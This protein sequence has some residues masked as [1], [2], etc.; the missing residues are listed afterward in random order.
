MSPPWQQVSVMAPP[1]TP[2]VQVPFGAQSPKQPRPWQVDFDGQLP[3]PLQLEPLV[4]IPWVHEP[5]VQLSVLQSLPSSQLTH[6]LP[7]TPQWKLE[8]ERHWPNEQQPLVQQA[9]P[10]QWPPLQVLPSL[11]FDHAVSLVVGWQ[12][13]QGFAELTAPEA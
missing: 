9:P 7:E 12:V 4:A 2:L 11:R 3:G 8:V 13:W 1:H 10:Q 6:A 5:L